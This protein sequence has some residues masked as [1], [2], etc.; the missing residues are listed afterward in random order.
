MLVKRGNL[1]I[2]IIIRNSQ[3]SQAPVVEL[4]DVLDGDCL[5]QSSSHVPGARGKNQ[6][7]DLDDDD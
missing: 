3:T 2:R 1:M 4:S 5:V 6:N 7:R